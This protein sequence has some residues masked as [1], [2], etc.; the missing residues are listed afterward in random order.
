MEDLFAYRNRLLA[1]SN[2]MRVVYLVDGPFLRSELSRFAPPRQLAQ[3][4]EI[5]SKQF[6]RL[7]QLSQQYHFICEIYLIEPMEDVTNGTYPRTARAITAIAHDLPVIDLGP[8]L[9]D[10]PRHY[11]Y[12][13]D[14]HF[15]PAGHQ[16]VGQ[17]LL[18]QSR[19]SLAK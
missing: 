4:L 18:E 14:G 17:F 10:D 5:T 8:V 3:A 13:F 19:G 16:V 1:I 2:L 9:R 6:A 7:T 12:R 11:Y 15:T